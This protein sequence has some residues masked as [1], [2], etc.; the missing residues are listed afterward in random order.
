MISGMPTAMPNVSGSLEHDSQEHRHERVDVSDHGRAR[1]PHFAV[2]VKKIRKP[3]AV[4]PGDKV[5]TA[6]T[7][8]AK[9]D[10]GMVSRPA[11]T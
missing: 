3:S 11:G 1:G 9:T 8:C 4:R 7:V 5:A 2:G 6:P 10:A